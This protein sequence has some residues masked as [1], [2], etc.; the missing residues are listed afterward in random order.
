MRG[1]ELLDALAYADADLILEAENA[2]RRKRKR[3]PA[4]R[5]ALI[6]AAAVLLGTTA[7]AAGVL[8]TRPNVRTDPSGLTMTADGEAAALPEEAEE[9][10]LA[11]VD[12][13]RG[14]KAYFEFD[15][16]EEWQAFFGLPF[17][18]FETDGFLTMG[19]IDTI[20]TTKEGEDGV[21]K[22]TSALSGSIVSR[23]R[24]DSAPVPGESPALL[25]SGELEILVSY[26]GKA[27]SFDRFE[28]AQEEQTVEDYTTPS[29]IPCVIAKT[30]TDG[31]QIAHFRL[32][33][34]FDAV[35]CCL[36]T[37]THTDSEEEAA[38]ILED[39]KTIADSL[40]IRSPG[41]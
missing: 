31:G 34:S 11:A 41:E 38:A 22:P 36:R 7:V 27:A 2:G 14:Y 9:A 13:E 10:I 37:H 8:L 6:A 33:Y 21:R 3:L 18:F 4:G 12:P 5:I 24:E 17:A 32:Y 1:N 20:V 19:P 16:V 23:Y 39:L 15:T 29:G 28:S 26:T 35:S 25:W 30:V 40:E